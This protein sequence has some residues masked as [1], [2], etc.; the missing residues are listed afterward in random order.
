MKLF[1]LL[2]LCITVGFNLT[3]NATIRKVLFIGN[4]Y[5]YTNNM[6]LMFQ[7]LTGSMGDTLIYDQST[8]GGYTFSMHDTTAATITKIF[9]QQWDIVVLQEQS[10]LPSFPPAE[11][12]TEVYPY[13]HRLD[14]LIHANDSCTQ[15]MF[16]MTWGHANGDPLNCS[17]YPVICTYTGMQLRLRQSYM[18][19]TQDNNAIVAPVGAAWQVM[20]DSFAPGI[21]LYISDSSHPDPSGSYLES[22][23]LYSSIFHKPTLGCTYTAGIASADAATIQRISDKVVLD[24]LAQWQQYGHYP[25]AGFTASCVADSAVLTDNAVIAQHFSWQFGDGSSLIDTNGN[26]TH[27]YAGSGTYTVSLT[28]SNNCFTETI[29]KPVSCFP[30]IIENIANERYKHIIATPQG[31]GNV[32]FTIPASSGFDVMEVFDTKG[33]LSKKYNLNSLSIK[34]NFVP[35]LYIVRVRS[36]ISGEFYMDKVVVY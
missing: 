17:S 25:Y 5:I 7:T 11:V 9:S 29:T 30:T 28:A 10:E 23:V 19:M 12:D 36:T 31:S 33:N 22:C 4:S 1:K 13:A 18:Q 16:L 34:D 14:S 20:M 35:G 21:W 27:N 26:T 6:P 3:A 32:L 8:I 24:S 2:L 15:T